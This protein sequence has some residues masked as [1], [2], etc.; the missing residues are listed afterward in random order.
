MQVSI[1]EVDKFEGHLLCMV[2]HDGD[3]NVRYAHHAADVDGSEPAVDLGD[4]RYEN[5]LKMHLGPQERMMVCKP[6]IGLGASCAP[7]GFCVLCL[8]I[9]VGASPA[10]VTRLTISILSSARQPMLAMDPA[11][12]PVSSVVPKEKMV[13]IHLHKCPSAACTPSR[14][15]STSAC[16]SARGK[17]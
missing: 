10:S 13:T 1:I 7:W 17:I 11:N 3:P 4:F 16:S 12:K 5:E 6:A 2:G 15:A 9:G 14:P 8:R